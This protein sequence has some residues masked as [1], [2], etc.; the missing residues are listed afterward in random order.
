M[1]RSLR[2]NEQI[3]AWAE[4]GLLTSEQLSALAARASLS[5][6]ELHWQKLLERVATVAGVVLLSAGVIFFFA[7]NWAEMHRF[8]KFALA[9]AGLT[10]FAFLAVFAR[11]GSTLYRSALLG[12]CIATGAVLALIGQTYQT[13]A[14]VWQLFAMWA[15]LM[16]PWAWLSGSAASWGLFW[17]VGNLALLAFFAQ[18]QWRDLF[19]GLQGYQ[20]LLV[21]AVSN[22]ALLL[23]FELHGRMLL[24]NPGRTVQRLTCLGVLA[25]LGCGAAGAWWEWAYTPLVPIFLLVAG[26]MLVFY[27][28]RRRDLPILSMVL[29]WLIVVGS[30]GLVRLTAEADA[31]FLLINTVALFVLVSSALSAVWLT[32]LARE[33]QA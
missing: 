22:G 2:Q 17:A 30:S 10:G 13:G 14:D 9:L 8:A 4:E 15:V 27:H 33:L 25:A 26:G 31:I 29:F 18:T 3:L 11:P 23:V 12:C 19:S 6:E 7:W 24:F 5:P 28:Q 1:S 21:L 32:R 16:I 20:I